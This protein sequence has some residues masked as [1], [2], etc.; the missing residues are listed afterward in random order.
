MYAGL[1]RTSE[2]EV[3][4]CAPELHT[5]SDR[6]KGEPVCSALEMGTASADDIES[7]RG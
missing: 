2:V 3:Q 5:D 6:T 4:T 1:D 7:S